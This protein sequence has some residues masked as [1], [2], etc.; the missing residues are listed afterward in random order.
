MQI[1]ER[2]THDVVVLDL[3]G[4][5][6][7]EDGAELLR[8]KFNSLIFTGHSKVLIN[9]SSVPHIDSG[10]LGELVSLLVTARHAQASLKL[11]GLTGRVVELL[12]IT[13]LTTEFD[14][15]DTERDAMSSYL[16]TA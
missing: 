3:K 2:R 11:Y 6:T 1:T 15:Y 14:T 12:T 7:V 8:D 5:L 4:R 9:L 13:K 10:S 16:V